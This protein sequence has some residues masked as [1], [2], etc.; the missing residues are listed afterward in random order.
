VTSVLERDV[1]SLLI[2]QFTRLP[3]WENE[4]PFCVLP[5]PPLQNSR[6]QKSRVKPWR[7]PGNRSGVSFGNA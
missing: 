6:L 5:R 4:P 2:D 7:L 3:E 1:T